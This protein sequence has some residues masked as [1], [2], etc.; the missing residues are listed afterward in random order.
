VSAKPGCDGVRATT[1]WQAGLP[2]TDRAP[3]Q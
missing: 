2:L 3:A 1:P